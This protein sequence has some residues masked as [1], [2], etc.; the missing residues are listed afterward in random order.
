M[1]DDSGRVTQRQLYETLVGIEERLVR[2]IDDNGKAIGELR[3]DIRGIATKQEE[4]S[5]EIENLRGQFRL[6]DI[7]VTIIS[8]AFAGIGTMI[9][10]AINKK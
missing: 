7:I 9:G 6:S 4:D 8:A 2:K 3:T 1:A 10:V 5:K